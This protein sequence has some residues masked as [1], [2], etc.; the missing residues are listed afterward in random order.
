MQIPTGL[1]SA[2][3]Q[4]RNARGESNAAT[5]RASRTYWDMSSTPISLICSTI[6]CLRSALR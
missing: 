6:F 2:Q 5:F 1:A 3:V 4:E